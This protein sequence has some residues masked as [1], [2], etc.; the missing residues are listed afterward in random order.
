MTLQSAALQC[1]NEEKK[2]CHSSEHLLGSHVP[3]DAVE[4][5]AKSYSLP[6]N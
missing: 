1:K 5:S 3:F 6:L 4:I 2:K